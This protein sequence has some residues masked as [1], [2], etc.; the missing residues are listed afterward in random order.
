MKWNSFIKKYKQEL[1]WGLQA[2]PCSFIPVVSSISNSERIMV[3]LEGENGISVVG[4]Q[5]QVPFQ[6]LWPQLAAGESQRRE[7]WVKSHLK[8]LCICMV[9]KRFLKWGMNIIS[10]CYQEDLLKRCRAVSA[11]HVVDRQL[12]FSVCGYLQIPGILLHFHFSSLVIKWMWMSLVLLC[13]PWN[14][15][16]LWLLKGAQWFLKSQVPLRHLAAGCISVFIN[17]WFSFF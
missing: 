15:E 3:T 14:T 1:F 10:N 4:F 13:S 17:C 6:Q 16:P 12:I 8:T 7:A 9:V 11:R 2:E 5:S